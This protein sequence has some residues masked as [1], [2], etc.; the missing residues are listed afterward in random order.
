MNQINKDYYSKINSPDPQGQCHPTKNGELGEAEFF[1]TANDILRE[2]VR[3]KQNPDYVTERIQRL[4]QENSELAK[5]NGLSDDYQTIKKE[6]AEPYYEESESQFDWSKTGECLA[7]KSPTLVPMG[8]GC[9]VAVVKA[10]RGDISKI[11]DVLAT[12]PAVI[13]EIYTCIEEGFE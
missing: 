4:I 8:A 1:K 12:C 9:G 10:V 11:K 5:K 3:E 13:K 7:G 6:I 2:G